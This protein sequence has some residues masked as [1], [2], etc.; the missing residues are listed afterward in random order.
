MPTGIFGLSRGRLISRSRTPSP[1]VPPGDYSYFDEAYFQEGEKRGTAY[2]DYLRSAESN[3]LNV[4]IA[5]ACAALKPRRA[6]EIGCA[7]GVIVAHLNRMGIEAHGIDVSQWAIENRAHPKVILSGAERLP[8]PNG[9]FDLVYSV[10]ALE[11]LPKNVVRAAFAEIAR[12]SASDA[13]QFHTLPILGLGPYSGDRDSTIAGLKKDP[14]HHLLKE[15]A[16]WLDRFR[17][18]GFVDVGAHLLFQREEYADLSVSQLLLARPG[19]G[20]SRLAQAK[21]WNGVTITRCLA[22]AARRESHR[23][24]AG[25]APWLELSGEW[26][27]VEASGEFVLDDEVVFTAVVTLEA[28]AE[29]NLRFCFLSGAGDESDLIRNYAPGVTEF[30]FRRRELL[31]RLGSAWFVRKVVFGGEGSGRVR[32]SLVAEKGDE[33]VFSM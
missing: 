10:H 12:V 29:T 24:L 3:P 16:W 30:Q 17:A 2:H 5:E 14:T 21:A 11:H 32:V 9:W 28:E 13:V 4:E 20:P 23:L 1:A 31:Q 15:E 27:D 7:T 19:D 6:L 18:I 22:A 25:R 26:A 8:F 33:T